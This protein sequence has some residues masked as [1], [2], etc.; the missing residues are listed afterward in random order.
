ML[1]YKLQH[2]NFTDTD[3]EFRLVANLKVMAFGGMFMTGL[4][5]HGVQSNGQHYSGLGTGK[6]VI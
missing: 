3:C 1:R 4:Y 2:I 6:I 5:Q